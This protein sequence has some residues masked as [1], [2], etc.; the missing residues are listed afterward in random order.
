M[1]ACINILADK[2]GYNFAYDEIYLRQNSVLICGL[3]I[4]SQSNGTKNQASF[5]A[6]LQNNKGVF[7]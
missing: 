7:I 5:T 4:H 1:F 2:E 3:L 6:L